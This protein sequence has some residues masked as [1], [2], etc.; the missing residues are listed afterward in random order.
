MSNTV[1][2]RVV[3]MQFDNKQFE[4]GIKTSMTTLEKFEKALHLDG[5][6]D[7]FRGL[8][9]SVR[10]F[11]LDPLA[12]AADTV[13]YKFNALQIMGITALSNITNSAVNTGK[14]LV[15]SLSVDQIT[16]GWEKFGNKTTSVATLLAQ[17]NDLEVVNDQLSRLNWFTDETSYNFTDMVSNIAKFTASGKG[18]EES[19]TAMEGIATWAALSGQNARTASNAMYQISQAMGAGIM[20]K[21]DYKS[22]QN[23]SMDTMEFRQKC[24]D[25]AVALGTLKDNGDGTYRSL[26][27]DVKDGDFAISQF[28][29]H[30]TQDAWFTSDVMMSVFNQF[31]GAVSKIYDVTEEKGLLASEVIDEIHKTAE[32]NNITI[33]EAIKKLGYVDEAGNQLFDSFGLKAF[34]AAQK[35]RTWA[36]AVDSV[37]DAVSTGWMNT[38]EIIFGNSEEATELWTDLANAMWDVFAAGGEARNEM[39]E[40]WKELGGRDDLIESFWNV[41]DGVAA[42][43][44]PIKDAF[45]DIFPA[46]TSERLAE[47]TKSLKAFTEKLT[48]APETADKVKRSFKGLFAVFD[49]IKQALGAV[50]TGFGKFIGVTKPIGTNILDMA[51]SL[52]D[53]LVTL[54]DTTRESGF[55][56]GVMDAIGKAAEYV[57][58]AF[59]KLTERGSQ[60]FEKLSGIDM[61][62]IEVK[63]E[64]LK[65][66]ADAWTWVIDKLTAAYEK[67]QPILIMAGSYIS[68]AFGKASEAISGFVQNGGLQSLNEILSGGLIGALIIGVTKIA[69]AFS[70]IGENA[71]GFLE[72][73]SGI[74]EGVTGALENMQNKLKTEALKNIAISIAVLAGSLMVLSLVNH[75]NLDS[76]ITAITVMFLELIGALK[77]LDETMKGTK[78]KGLTK[79]IGQL[80]GFSTA[81]LI[82]SASMAILGSI[83]S[84]GIT[85]GLIAILTLMGMLTLVAQKLG[86]NESL[87]K[88][89]AG[90]LIAFSAAIGILALSV[91]FLGSMDIA[92]IAKGLGALGGILAELALFTKVYDFSSISASTGVGLMAMAMAL[93]ILSG[94]ISTFGHMDLGVMAQGLLVMAAGLTALVIAA[95]ALPKEGMI[96]A[97]VGL[98]AIATALLIVGAALHIMGN[99]S[100]EEMC[101]GLLTMAGALTILVVAANM[102]KGSIGGA[103]AILIMA[104]A[105]VVLGAALHIIGSMSVEQVV[106]ALVALAATL[107]IIGIAAVLMTPVIPALL[108][109]AG[110]IL[111]L[112]VAVGIGGVA[113]LAFG[114]GLTAVGVGLSALVTGIVGAIITIIS[115]ITTIAEDIGSAIVAIA[116]A[117]NA[118][119]PSVAEAINV[120]VQAIIDVLVYAVVSLSEA[121]VQAGPALLILAGYMIIFG[122]AC[123]VLAPLA[124]AIVAVSAALAAF[125]LSCATIAVGVLTLAGAL[126]L[127]GLAGLTV[128]ASLTDI[129]DTITNM[130]NVSMDA[131]LSCAELFNEA[132]EKA[133]EMILEGF[134][135]GFSTA[136]ASIITSMKTAINAMQFIETG[137]LVVT[138]FTNGIDSN[139]D[140]PVDSIRGISSSMLNAIRRYTSSFYS[141]GS[142]I[143]SGLTNGIN[144]NRWRAINAATDLG[145]ATK[146]A[147]QVS[148][149][150][151]SPSRDFEDIGMW[152]DMGLANGLI[153]FAGLAVNAAKNLGNS[154]IQPIKTMASNAL[155]DIGSMGSALRGTA[156]LASGLD[157]NITSE[158]YVTVNH[159]FDDLTVKGVNDRDEFVAVANYSV[160]DMLT[161][162]MR[163]G[164]RR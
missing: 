99:L 119:A 106:T 65:A 129:Y 56:T 27:A 38:F 134:N 149:D 157:S 148:V 126:E 82:L 19:V 92:S 5:I 18:L 20:R 42:V 96:A 76:A 78:S 66:V 159:T 72:N 11:T 25:A 51:A 17:G 81:I 80:I 163:K 85:R 54:S 68:S 8:G 123:A 16:A 94:A 95:E 155:S 61:S 142:D 63:F 39:L 50:T 32:D 44:K 150:A 43:V 59:Q 97:G 2:R 90:Q 49:I 109:L 77:V 75:N 143:V 34:E 133:A 108:G 37:K 103:T 45:R 141:I 116:E 136:S 98:M 137:T 115:S 12:N 71:G 114:T 4:S 7:G 121:L 22:I 124:P 132:G 33:D 144:D 131:V 1:D 10:S 73:L 140:K 151:H 112:S 47:M 153:K 139:S 105:L 154:A 67:V 87:M 46:T 31:S 93:L 14:Q 3:E 83:D 69:N 162:L 58:G 160:E 74:F 138:Y 64:P 70:S 145:N 164:I 152:C 117:I 9:Q 107:A 111:L 23:A 84:N 156:A 120:V 128:A 55:F 89:G 125:G 101:K 35:A 88:K 6:A 130:G 147:M 118:A 53:F 91:K 60:L 41:W 62:G 100:W 52:G 40:G 113:L 161:D 79:A 48:I 26:V 86:K 102:M 29:D 57:S 28:A 127:L 30:L 24:L 146:S 21:E 104:G 13:A 158:Q 36:D 135:E 110:A 15:K 122:A